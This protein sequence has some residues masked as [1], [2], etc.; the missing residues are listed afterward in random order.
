MKRSCIRLSLLLLLLFLTSCGGSS[1]PPYFGVFLEED[2]E[3]LEMIEFRGKPDSPTADGIPSTSNPEPIIVMWNPNVV[4]NYLGMSSL[5]GAGQVGYN[6]SLRDG[7]I[8]EIR[9]VQSLANDTYCLTQGDPLLPFQSLSNWC[10]RVGQQDNTASSS[11][12]VPEPTIPS[13]ELGVIGYR[14]GEIL[15]DNTAFGVCQAIDESCPGSNFVPEG[16]RF[17]I[18]EIA[19]ENDTCCAAYLRYGYDRSAVL[20]DSGGF[21]RS[22]YFPTRQLVDPAAIIVPHTRMRQYVYGAI[23]MNQTPTTIRLPAD[24]IVSEIIIDLTNQRNVTYPFATEVIPPSIGSVGGSDVN[25]NAFHIAI[26]DTVVLDDPNPE[27]DSW[28]IMGLE[29]ELT[30]NGGYDLRIDDFSVLVEDSSGFQ[31]SEIQN[32]QWPTDESRE[33]IA[34]GETVRFTL[35]TWVEKDLFTPGAASVS[36]ALMILLHNGLEI[37]GA[38]SFS[39]GS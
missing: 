8:L 7:D 36:Q 15:Y 31:H 39:S 9:P 38:Y 21:E 19:I 33:T 27:F 28:M 25:G 30:N 29:V 32:N 22:T 3:L 26:N 11:N 1:E 5:T 16:W 24:G 18:T 34:P 2:G 35:A 17:W 23:P 14:V 37:L 20:I 6:V 10:F 12:I 4:L 13:Q